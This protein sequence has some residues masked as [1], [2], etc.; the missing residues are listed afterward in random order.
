MIVPQ[1]WAEARI[2]SRTRKGQ[3]TI[4]RF[5]WSDE[6]QEAAEQHA[7]QRAD[8]AMVRAQH[9]R[10][11]V[12]REPL[13]PYNG[14]D[15]VPIREEIVLRQGDS[16]V[17]RNSYGARCL[18]TPDVL[19]ADIDVSEEPSAS[20]TLASAVTCSLIGVAIAW[21]AVHWATLALLA[22]GFFI[23]G[24]LA[25]GIIYRWILHQ[26]PGL[27]GR[28]I[29]RINRFIDSHR[30]WNVRV[31]RTPAGL[32]VLALHRT[33]SPREPE[34]E[35]FFKAVKCDPIYALMCRNQNCFRARVSGK[36]WRMGMP[37][38]VRPPGG[39]WP[40][41]ESKRSMREHW[42]D[43]YEHLASSFSACRFIDALGNGRVDARARA[44]QELHDRLCQADA[45][46]PLA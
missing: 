42:V 11:L 32:R 15:G 23:V 35:E 26:G 45:S 46:L 21:N 1:Y 29:E 20:V 5:G 34:V 6:S 12:R 30:D 25:S 37:L 8:E 31:Y 3:V 2:Q 38:P 10:S 40:I 19:F 17:T 22:G 16:V 33:F 7:R 41:A 28:V 14:A 44:V 13:T 43:R 18:N 4:R 24:M 27:E 39:V 36:P 9:D